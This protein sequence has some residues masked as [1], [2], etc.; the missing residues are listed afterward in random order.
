MVIRIRII[1][2]KV[3]R[4]KE[5]C[6]GLIVLELFLGLGKALGDVGPVENVEDGVNVRATKVLVLEIV[7]MLP[8]VN[9]QK[10]DQASGCL[11]WVLVLAG[12]DL[13]L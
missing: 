8:N 5:K 11:Q 9:A 13:E 7:G 6:I 2:K 3:G 4:I 1:E 10:W 12:G